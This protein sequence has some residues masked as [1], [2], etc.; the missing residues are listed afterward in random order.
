VSVEGLGVLKGNNI[1]PDARI[2]WHGQGA[3][4][5]ARALLADGTT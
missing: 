4:W 3:F 5:A 1:L 2:E